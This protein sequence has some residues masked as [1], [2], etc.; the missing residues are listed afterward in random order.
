ME[1]NCLSVAQMLQNHPIKKEQEE[2]RRRYLRVLDYMVRK[3]SEKDDWANAALTLYR[4]VLLDGKD[5]ICTE[6]DF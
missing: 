2:Y 4:S 3:Y 5:Y 6:K 1:F